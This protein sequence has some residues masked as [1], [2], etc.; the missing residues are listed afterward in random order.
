MCG[1]P[2][3][4]LEG[5]PQQ[6]TSLPS[7]R[8]SPTV[9]GRGGPPVHDVRVQGLGAHGAAAPG[10]EAGRGTY[11]SESAGTRPVDFSHLCGFGQSPFIPPSCPL[12]RTA[13]F[14][15]FPP[16]TSAGLARTG[17]NTAKRIM[18]KEGS[19]GVLN[20]RST[21]VLIEQ[22]SPRAPARRILRIW[23]VGSDPLPRG[24]QRRPDSS[25][26]QATPGA[27]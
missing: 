7:K 17:N 18:G 16:Q 9:V 2:L 26:S 20:I 5:L 23:E 11:R 24:W 10:P 14:P 12:P 13:R 15:W 25:L 8:L 6:E 27:G 22:R 19:S 3:N 1:T 21:R 4:G